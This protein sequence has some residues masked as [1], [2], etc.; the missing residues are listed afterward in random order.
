METE[1]FTPFRLSRNLQRLIGSLL[2][3]GSMSASMAAVLR[4]LM[5]NKEYL[6]HH[7]TLTLRDDIACCRIQEPEQ[8]SERKTEI[9]WKAKLRE[10]SEYNT[11]LALHRLSDTAPSYSQVRGE[12]VSTADDVRMEWCRWRGSIS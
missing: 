6:R 3:R 8:P 4:C 2:T 12:R 7:L 10:A 11:E 1:K 5:D 9:E